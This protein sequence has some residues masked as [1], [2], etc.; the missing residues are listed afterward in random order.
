ML[1]LAAAL[2]F[3]V[4]CGGSVKIDSSSDESF[5]KSLQEAKESLNSAERKEFEKAIKIIAFSD[6]DNVSELAVDSDTMS[7]ATKDKL[8]RKLWF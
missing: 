6:P 5:K 2:I 4:G 7:R 1:M 8:N 3:I